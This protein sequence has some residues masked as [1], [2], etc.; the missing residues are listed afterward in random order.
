MIFTGPR[1]SYIGNMEELKGKKVAVID[2]YAIHELLAENHPGVILK[3]AR[4]II[5]APRGLSRGETDAFV[6]NILTTGHYLSRLGFS[7]IKI[8]GETPY[9]HDQAFAVRKENAILASI[10]QKGV[11]AIPGL[12]REAADGAEAVQIAKQWTP[13]LIWMDIRMPIMDGHEATRRIKAEARSG[14]KIIALTAHAFEEDRTRILAAGCDGFIRKPF[15]EHE[16]L[17]A[18]REHLGV[19]YIY[20]T[21]DFRSE[22]GAM[23]EHPEDLSTD[24]LAALDPELPTALKQAIIHGSPDRI[25]RV[26]EKIRES[27]PTLADAL[28]KRANGF[29]YV[30]ILAMIQEG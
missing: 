29:E 30:R 3:P 2:G 28:E 19:R 5:Y 27:D 7:R 4:N 14:V 22:A 13:D 9:S 21:G 1:I 16:I 15:K 26:I 20:E 8:S 25:T 10:L 6:G 11:D 23:A 12:E 18:M 24:A 17:E